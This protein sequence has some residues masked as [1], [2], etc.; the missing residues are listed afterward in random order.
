MLPAQNIDLHPL[1][2]YGLPYG[3]FSHII[4]RMKTT[5]VLDEERL[6]RIREMAGLKTRR[7]TIDFALREAERAIRLSRLIKSPLADDEFAGAVDPAYD[8]LAVREREKPSR[9]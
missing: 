1:R 7:E 2:S 9:A 6:E 3:G 5:I 4:C 8:V